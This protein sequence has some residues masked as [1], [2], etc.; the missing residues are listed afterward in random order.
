[1]MGR[2]LNDDIIYETE[3]FI[4]AVP[5]KPHIP[6]ENGGHIWIRSKEK[7]FS[8]RLDLSV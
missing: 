2:I 8:S 3:N 7:Y 5:K 1:M 6:R 4:V